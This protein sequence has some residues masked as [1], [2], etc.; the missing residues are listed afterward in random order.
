LVKHFPQRPGV[1]WSG[2]LQ[3]GQSRQAGGG[4]QLSQSGSVRVPAAIA[5]WRPQRPQSAARRWQ[6]GHHGR[7]VR[8]EMPQGV[9]SPQIEQVLI[10]RV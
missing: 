10:G 6:V 5:V 7:P 2:S 8:L 4:A 9:V 3:V 1:G